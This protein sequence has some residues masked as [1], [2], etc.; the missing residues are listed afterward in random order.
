[1]YFVI[2]LVILGIVFFFFL[3]PVFQR[4]GGGGSERTPAPAPSQTAPPTSQPRDDGVDI[5][6]PD[7]IDVNINQKE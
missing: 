2:F 6:V 1:M 4:G 5:R 3:W 7:E